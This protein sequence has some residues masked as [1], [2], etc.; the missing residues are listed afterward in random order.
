MRELVLTLTLAMGLVP[1]QM[2]GYRRAGSVP[3]WPSHIRT[4]AIPPFQNTSMHYRVE[5]RFTQAVMAE[6]I[7]RGRHLRITATPEDADAVLNGNI[8]SVALSGALLDEAG[9][10]RLYQVT[11]SVAVTVRDRS[12]NR[13]LFDNPNLVFR[14][15]YELPEGPETLFDEEGPA[16]ERIAREFARSLVTTILRGL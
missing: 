13:L 12:T 3:H 15:E 9:R 14:G 6:F 2:C 11:I 7:R 8:R 5:Q 1:V 10:V 16:V 4:I